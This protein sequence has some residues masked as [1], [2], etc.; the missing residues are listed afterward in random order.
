MRTI[1]PKKPGICQQGAEELNKLIP[2]TIAIH[3]FLH[4]AH[5]SAKGMAFEG[6]HATLKEA[7]EA[8]FDLSDDVKERVRILG[9]S[10]AY[11]PKTATIKSSFTEEADEAT[12]CTLVLD[13]M[14]R[15][16]EK[17]DFAYER[18]ED[19]R[20]NGTS[21]VLQDHL[22]DIEKIGWKVATHLESLPKS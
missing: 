3:N 7:Y 17:L 6:L 10:L 16:A 2:D 13:E 4:D 12:L 9:F 11:D 19:L 21:K 20:L 8:L 14:R 18:L 15:Y 1:V 5:V 22:A